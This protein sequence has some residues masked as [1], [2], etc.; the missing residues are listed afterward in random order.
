MLRVRAFGVFG[1]GCF[2]RLL[3]P[4]SPVR[5]FGLC[6]P[7]HV[8]YVRSRWGYWQGLCSG[9]LHNLFIAAPRDIEANTVT[10]N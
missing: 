8:I 10:S 9:G 5:R 1:L 3:V 7:P 2:F 6:F 4:F